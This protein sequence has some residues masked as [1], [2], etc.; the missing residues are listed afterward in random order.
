MTEQ[1]LDLAIIGCSA[2]LPEG[3]GFAFE[4]DVTIEVKEGRIA[5]IGRSRQ[6]TEPEAGR[7]IDG[8]GL[9]ALPGFINAHTHAAMTSF[10][11]AVEDVA[12][13]AWFNDHV[14]PMEVNLEP[15]DVWLGTMLGCAEMIESG[16][17]MFADHY[18]FADQ[19]AAAVESSG[20]R[21]NLGWT[22]LG[23]QGDAGLGR[24][25]AFCEEWNGRACGRITT[26]IAPHAPYTCDDRQ[27]S[28][29]AAAAERLGARVHIHAAEHLEQTEASVRER[30]M[31][32]IQQLENAGVLTAGALIAHGCGVVDS[33]LPL[34]EARRGRVAFV[35]CPKVY[36]KH[37]LAPL[38]PIRALLERRV[39]VGLGTDG[40]AG[41]NT[42]DVAESLRLMALTQ[43][44]VE[45]DAAW[46][47]LS[48]ALQLAGP[49]S[50][51]AV[52]LDGRIGALAP[53]YR[54]DIVLVDLS[55]SHCQPV[56]DPAAAIV[57]SMRASDVR[58]TIVDGAVLMEDRKLLTLQ[59]REILDEVRDRLPRLL[60]TAHGR[61]VASY[62]PCRAAKVRKNRNEHQKGG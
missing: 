44:H 30:G 21:A 42:L 48:T 41:C 56:H 61:R 4:D 57:Y 1:P 2:L 24:S 32:P 12:V 29:A 11:G 22:F 17:T 6:G 5:A 37:G 54:A 23:N 7:R 31:T 34:L 18:F 53:G 19:V 13:D 45:R 60:D 8:R 10:R 25:I 55:G 26:S 58:T 15:R 62:P 43:K 3:S 52:G 38:T 14:W 20:L 51:A 33:D 27:L 39:V 35:H 46:M 49:G 59:T 16:V 40:A 36:L 50:A 28:L 9:Y 47:P